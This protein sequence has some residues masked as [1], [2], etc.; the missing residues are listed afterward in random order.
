MTRTLPR[1]PAS[2]RRTPIALQRLAQRRDLAQ[3]AALIR[4]AFVEAR[5]EAGVLLRHALAW[6]DRVHGDWQG[7]GD[8]IARADRLGEVVS[9]VEEH[10]VHTGSHAGGQVRYDGVGHGGRHAP[11]VA[12]LILSPPQDLDRGGALELVSAAFGQAPQRVGIGQYCRH[13]AYLTT[14]S[15]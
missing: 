5:T 11:R 10:H 9:G 7:R 2:S 3:R 4:I 14:G 13:I 1:E 8:G 15:S 6:G 12:E